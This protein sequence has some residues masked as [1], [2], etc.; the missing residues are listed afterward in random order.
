MLKANMGIRIASGLMIGV[1]LLGV[2][3]FALSEGPLG[4]SISQ[5][6][7]MSQQYTTTTTEIDH[8]HTDS[9]K[10][11]VSDLAK[12]VRDRAVDCGEVDDRIDD[13]GYPG[14]EDTRL[15][16]EPS[17]IGGEASA[18]RGGIGLTDFVPVIGDDPED[19]HMAGTLSREDFRI[20]GDPEI[21]GPI[22]FS[23]VEED[24]WLEEG[25]IGGVSYE[26]F[27]NA[28]EPGLGSDEYRGSDSRFMVFFQDPEVGA[29]RANTDM[30]EFG[31]NERI[32]PDEDS[33]ENSNGVPRNEFNHEVDLCPG[34][35]GYIQLNRDTPYNTGLADESYSDRNSFPII[36]I[37]DSEVEECGDDFQGIMPYE[38]HEW[39]TEVHIS[40]AGNTPF[41]DLSDFEV[42][43]EDGTESSLPHSAP[44]RCNA[45]L[46]GGADVGSDFYSD[47]YYKTGTVFESDQSTLSG[48]G[49]FPFVERDQEN[50]PNLVMDNFNLDGSQQDLDD[51]GD[52]DELRLRDPNLGYNEIYG[53]LLCANTQE[54][55][56]YDEYGQ[57]N[58]CL[59][60]DSNEL[61]V[62][63]HD[64]VCSDGSR[65]WTGFPNDIKDNWNNIGDEDM[66]EEG[67]WGGEEYIQFDLDH[68]DNLD[69]AIWDESLIGGWTTISVELRLMEGEVLTIGTSE[70]DRGPSVQFNRDIQGEQIITL[71]GDGEEEKLEY[72]IEHAEE[73]RVVFTRPNDQFFVED[74]EGN[75]LI[76]HN[77]EN[78]FALTELDL[79]D[80][81]EQDGIRT[82][83][84]EIRVTP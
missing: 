81:A 82:Q 9:S 64:F 53:D 73:L 69:F 49:G 5:G 50:R 40:N 84:S 58:I 32:W 26:A 77:S 60:E 25:N 6:L 57:W 3:G 1:I 52:N 29:N 10:E 12:F 20:G 45:Y 63:G 11:A 51:L 67:S 79:F 83:I 30:T 70:I 27:E 42:N 39:G 72:N 62:Q 8:L 22:R 4:S 43:R 44:N 71:H 14:L 46:W 18:F 74:S 17:C 80:N 61:E 2:V 33:R 24:M 37:E 65:D 76:R 68:S 47:R 23:E 59:E 41:P 21:D 28:I 31:Y 75:E 34:D 16:D 56:D 7:E 78:I 48:I 38:G 66:I 35:E 13:G 15:T 54:H 19:N 36:V 55:G